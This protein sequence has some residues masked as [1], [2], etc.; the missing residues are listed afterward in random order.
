MNILSRILRMKYL[1][2][3]ETQQLLL[4]I[5]KL[6]PRLPRWKNLDKYSERFHPL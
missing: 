6:T 4:T 3:L 2:A 1:L 5:Q